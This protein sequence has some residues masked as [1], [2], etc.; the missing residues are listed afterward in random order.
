MVSLDPSQRYTLE[1]PQMLNDFS[2]KTPNQYTSK[3]SME[4]KINH[5]KTQ[6]DLKKLAERF[7][8]VISAFKHRENQLLKRCKELEEEVKKYKPQ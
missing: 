5:E 2:P 3:K 4:W 6:I 1:I 7:K 8:T